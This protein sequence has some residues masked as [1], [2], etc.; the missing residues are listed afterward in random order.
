MRILLQIESELGRTRNNSSDY[1]DRNIDIDILLIDN[2]I[3]FSKTL[4]CSAYKN[5]GT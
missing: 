2:E 3:I 4:I 1:A 5:V